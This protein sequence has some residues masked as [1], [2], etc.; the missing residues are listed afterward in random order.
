M[1]VTLRTRP[2]V[3]GTGLATQSQMGDSAVAELVKVAKLVW[4]PPL[5]RTF[6]LISL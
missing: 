1:R 2:K 5:M 6:P 4:S 3:T